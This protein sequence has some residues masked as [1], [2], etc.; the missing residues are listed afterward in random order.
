MI[1]ES[2]AFRSGA[3]A[4]PPAKTFT[5]AN[6]GMYFATGSSSPSLPSSTRRRTPTATTGLVIE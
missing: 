1:G 3:S 4:V 2:G 5:L 6:D